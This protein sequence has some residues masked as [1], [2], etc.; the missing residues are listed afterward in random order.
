MNSTIMEKGTEP[1]KEA[2]IRPRRK[3]VLPIIL[4]SITALILLILIG[5]RIYFRLPVAQYYRHSE[6]AFVI[7]DIN[8]GFVPQGL[9][10]DDRSDCF[11]ITGHMKE[12]SKYA[13]PIYVVKKSDG[14]FIKKLIMHEPDGGEFHGHAGGLTV[15]GDYIYVAGSADHCLYIFSYIEA[16]EL[17]DGDSITSLGS[18]DMPDDLSVAYVA[19]D[20]EYLYSGE[21]Y[22]TG[23]HK[24]DDSHKLTT[25]AGDYN[26]AIIYAY[27]FSD[28]ADSLFGLSLKPA[29]AYSV[30][31][32]VQGMEINDGKIYLSTSYGAAF[33]HIYVY[34]IPESSRNFTVSELTMPLYELD[35]AS[36]TGTYKFPPMS[37]E[38]VFSDGKLYT[39]CESAS[40][41]Y[42][43]GKLTSAY[44]CYATDPGREK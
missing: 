6:K 44:H 23:S 43:F 12:K 21:F 8:K 22:R 3:K 18:F 31:D 10:Y 29:K 24:T 36:L 2:K 15:H 13:S 32:L 35:S 30:P 1:V 40:N 5:A 25:A 19:S 28:G 38:I 11:F 27:R 16:M 14:S 37:E 20:G 7:P 4:L 33:S 41:K 17:N 39:M 9:A 42:I 34:R 26:Q